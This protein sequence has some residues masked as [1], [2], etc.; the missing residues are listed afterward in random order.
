[1][2]ATSSA[3]K[4]LRASVVLGQKRLRAMPLLLKGLPTWERAYAS[5]RNSAALEQP[6]ER[7]V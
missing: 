4:K 7:Y 1:M 3:Q 5:M 6:S 2:L